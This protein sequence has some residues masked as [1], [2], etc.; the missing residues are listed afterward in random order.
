MFISD[1]NLLVVGVDHGFCLMKTPH[2]IFENGVHPLG[3]ESTLPTNTLEY[4]GEYFKVGE[5]RL[6]MM[7][8]K[9]SDDN[10]FRLTLA[11]IA[12]EMD[13]YHQKHCDVILAVGLPFSR[14][15]REKEDFRKYL[16]REGE[17]CFRFGGKEYGI[18]IQDV[19]VFPQCYAAIVD[20][21]REYGKETL[22]V[23]IGS[24]TIDVIHTKNYVPVESD[25]TSIAEAMIQCMAGIKNEVYQNCNRRINE[26][27]IQRIVMGEETTLPDECK[28]FVELGLSRFANN[29][30]A[31]LSEQG[32]DPDMIPVIYLGGGAVVMKQ[33]GSRRGDNIFYMDDVRANAKGF[34]YLAKQ[35]LKC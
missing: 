10:Y 34:E 17:I 26:D 4:N 3:G 1:K 25:S 35:K 18:T 22:V 11:A 23:D 13:V 2:H 7:D 5:G 8:V 28:R 31:K 32:F 21:L 30:E 20:R 9:T 6:P 33:Y 19:Y 15:A 16:L 27:A 12:K 24:K 29:V 14:F